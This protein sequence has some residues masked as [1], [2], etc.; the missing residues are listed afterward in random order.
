[1][2]VPALCD[3][4]GAVY[5]SAVVVE[6]PVRDAYAGKDAGR[7]PVCGSAGRFRDDIF[8]LIASVAELLAAPDRTPA[9]LTR[10]VDV[11][12]EASE[13]RAD[14]AFV[15]GRIR[16]DLP[17]LS[18]FT[19]WLPEGRQGL[20]SLIT[21]TVVLSVMT[22][23]VRLRDGAAANV[24]LQQAVDRIFAEADAAATSLGPRARASTGRNAPC[25]CGSGKK[26]KHCCGR[27][28]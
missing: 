27:I 23:G 7:C 22:V 26:Y 6:T 2:H 11:M 25:H 16:S 3:T 14:S 15:A 28:S 4:C 18:G 20:N 1:M 21:I 5:R 19:E 13:Q 8:E 24:S 12:N 10:L 17:A 9:E